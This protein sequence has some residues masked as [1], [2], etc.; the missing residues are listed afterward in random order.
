MTPMGD[1][2]DA[3]VTLAQPANVDTV[4]VN[5]RILRRKNQF[6]TLDLD[7]MMQETAQTIEQLKK[8]AG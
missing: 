1:A 6:T 3:L 4:I 8:A 2:Y 5:G 7:R